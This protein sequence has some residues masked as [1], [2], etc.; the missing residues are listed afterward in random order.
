MQNVYAFKVI[1][2]RNLAKAVTFVDPW[3]FLEEDFD[4]FFTCL[5]VLKVFLDL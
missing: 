5:A 3:R 4:F 1:G 2:L